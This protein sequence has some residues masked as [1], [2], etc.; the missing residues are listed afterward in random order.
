MVKE[1]SVSVKRFTYVQSS[2][3]H[4]LNHQM[5]SPTSGDKRT[6]IYE[7]TWRSYLENIK[8]VSRFPGCTITDLHP[9]HLA[10]RA[11]QTLNLLS[12]IVPSIGVQSTDLGVL[13]S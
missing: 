11:V 3:W 8:Y 10:K 4:L 2:S 12:F 7:I 13:K 6:L 9:S 5:I 1:T